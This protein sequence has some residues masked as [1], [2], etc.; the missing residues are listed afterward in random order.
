MSAHTTNNRISLYEN[1]Y[2]LLVLVTQI[3]W[4]LLN[5][6]AGNELR[7]AATDWQISVA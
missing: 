4:M 1:A 7:I 5:D 2:S 6:E 3:Q